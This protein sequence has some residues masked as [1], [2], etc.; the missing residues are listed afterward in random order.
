MPLKMDFLLRV[1]EVRNKR[2]SFSRRF[3]MTPS[4]KRVQQLQASGRRVVVAGDL[5][6]KLRPYDSCSHNRQVNLAAFRAS[7]PA[8]GEPAVLGRL[9]AQLA[10]EEDWQ[11]FQQRLLQTTETE[12]RS[13]FSYKLDDV[14]LKSELVSR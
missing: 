5:N 10:S 7:S 1:R 12:A 6:L 14:P 11:L 4:L 13:R 2:S 8:E 9:R 3:Q